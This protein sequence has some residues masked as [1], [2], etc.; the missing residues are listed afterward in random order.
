MCPINF[1]IVTPRASKRI[2]EDSGR[3]WHHELVIRRGFWKLPEGVDTRA[4]FFEEDSGSFRKERKG[5]LLSANHTAKF[6][7]DFCE[8]PLNCL[9]NH[10]T[11]HWATFHW[12]KQASHWFI[13]SFISFSQLVNQPWLPSLC[14]S[15]SAS[16]VV[17]QTIPAAARSSAPRSD[18]S[19]SSSPPSL[20]G[21]WVLS[22]GASIT[23]KAQKSWLNLL[24]SSGPPFL[25]VSPS[26]H[27]PYIS[28]PL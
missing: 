10:T 9:L 13:D 8:L 26:E 19:L 2:P 28:W 3:S 15:L 7:S 16:N 11:N 25:L 17:T 24:L 27:T 6:V 23:R 5:H 14:A 21:P 4:S 18:S 1:F 12:S 22:S 20:S